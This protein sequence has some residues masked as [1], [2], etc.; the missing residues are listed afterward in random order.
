MY[1]YVTEHRL[2]NKIKFIINLLKNKILLTKLI[3]K[4]KMKLTITVKFKD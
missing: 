3:K 4:L 1:T 2:K